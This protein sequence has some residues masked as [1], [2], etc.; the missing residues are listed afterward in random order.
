MNDYSKVVFNHK[1]PPHF[2]LYEQQVA[3]WDLVSLP[4][5]NGIISPMTKVIVPYVITQLT[6]LLRKPTRES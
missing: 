3:R 4:L 2:T 5:L 6:L 1:Q